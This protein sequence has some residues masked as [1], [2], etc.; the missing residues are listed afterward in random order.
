MDHKEKI[1]L[2]GIQKFG[3]EEAWREHQRQAGAKARRDTPRG[4]F[5]LKQR[6]PERLKAISKLGAE[7][8]W[9]KDQRSQS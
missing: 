4:F 7:A 9:A 5:V 2:A 8:K 6:D 3:S 1:R